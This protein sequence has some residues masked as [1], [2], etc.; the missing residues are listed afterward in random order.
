[1]DLTIVKIIN[2]KTLKKNSQA[3]M[4]IVKMIVE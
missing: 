1:M 4:E 2:E 3:L